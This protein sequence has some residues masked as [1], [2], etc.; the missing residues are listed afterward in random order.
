MFSVGAVLSLPHSIPLTD[1][2][3]KDIFVTDRSNSY[4]MPKNF[5]S[6]MADYD[7]MVID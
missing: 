6:E 2:P 3:K 5:S 7:W 1:F 4:A